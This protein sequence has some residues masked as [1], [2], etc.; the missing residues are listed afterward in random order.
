MDN[1]HPLHQL[2]SRAS[3][4]P[5]KSEQ[6]LKLRHGILT[7]SEVASALDCNSHESSVELLK[8]KC[9]PLHHTKLMTSTSIDWGEKY[10]PIAKQV[11]TKLT[12]DVVFDTGLIIHKDIPWLGAS[13]DGVLTSKKL[14]EI[15]CPFHRNIV[16]GRIPYYYWIQ[17][18]IQLEVC[19]LSECYFL[20]C[21][22]EENYVS[23]PT[24]GEKF[25]G[26]HPNGTE[27]YLKKYTLDSIARD[28]EW[29]GKS[30]P[31]LTQFWHKVEHYRLH[32]LN[33]LAADLGNKQIYYNLATKSVEVFNKSPKNVSFAP[34]L[35]SILD[36]PILV[37]DRP[38]IAARSD[39]VEGDSSLSS[40]PSSLPSSSLPSS[41]LSSLPSSSLSLPSSSLPSSSLPSSSLPL[42]PALSILGVKRRT[43]SG[44]SSPRARTPEV[45]SLMPTA[46][47]THRNWDEWVAA[48]SI[49]NYLMNDPILDW[50]DHY[51]KG[52]KRVK[53]GNAVYDSQ[54]AQYEIENKN[55]SVFSNFLQTH[56]CKFE[57]SVIANI[58]A[59]YGDDVIVIANPYQ[60]RQTDL[61]EETI[62][63]MSVGIPIICQAVFHNESN[64]TYGIADLLIRSDYINDLVAHPPLSEEETTIGC[65]FSKEWHYVV[66]DI[67]H[68]T[69]ELRADGTHLLQSGPM[70]AYKGQLYVYNMALGKVQ[71]YQPNAAYILG[72][73]WHYR[74]GKD[75]LAGNGWF[76]RLAT[77]AFTT[78]DK[79][80]VE[81]TENALEWVRLLRKKGSTWSFEPPSRPELY[82][83]MCNDRDVPWHAIKKSIA[84]SVGEITS[85]YYAGPA[86]RA[87]A[88]SNGI[89]SWMDP[90]CTAKNIGIKGGIIGPVVD[91]ILNTNRS[92]TTGNKVVWFKHKVFDI[93]NTK[94]SIFLDFE[95]VNDLVESSNFNY[96]YGNDNSYIFMIGIGWCTNNNLSKWHYK[97]LTVDVIDAENEKK[98]FL[99]MH[100]I[101][102]DLIAGE[103]FTIYHWSHAERT[104]Y[105]K[106]FEKYQDALS[107][108]A[109]VFDYHW[110]DMYTM[111]R[112]VPICV[113]GA[114]DFSLKSIASAM[115]SHG[116]I[117][118]NWPSDGILDGLNA[119]V[120][121]SE[122][123]EEAK[124]LGVSMKTI[125]V[126]QHIIN[127]NEVDCKVLMEILAFILRC[128]KDKKLGTMYK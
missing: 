26:K 24:N 22:F 121:A 13:P 25:Q 5:Q 20:Q 53:T 118:T 27:W 33:K 62:D 48:T 74:A 90:K 105:T 66:I 31:L 95:T 82:P 61:V 87:I 102:S 2:I 83:N 28:A 117:Q 94:V 81:K 111:F 92:K 125:P 30:L 23:S 3:T 7:S 29:F 71:G 63:A 9:T 116:L 123:S 100:K 76:D 47:T 80:I 73:K 12:G 1:S 104:F 67:K 32:G 75:V 46:L 96:A 64:Q 78:L 108:Y 11:F 88:H 85:V 6:W 51:G 124:R 128:K 59:K 49:Q 16:Q 56:G 65:K 98:I 17:V 45:G 110:F 8:R 60:A 69:L 86:N 91:M 70:Q 101:I 21:Q 107:E 4:V 42:P 57:D 72:R 112:E 54:I 36:P 113:K 58:K 41:S 126:L 77:V 35:A 120:K 114:L 37:L 89:M 122:C 99:E 109:N 68:I 50:F 97:C 115:H 55:A 119:M 44:E 14:L 84:K 52:N 38:V 19:D 34:T 93:P 40:L 39:N 103:E 43:S 127:Y 10:E 15:K 18:Q 79:E 106:T